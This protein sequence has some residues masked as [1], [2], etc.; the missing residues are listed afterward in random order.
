MS[1]VPGGPGSGEPYL[2]DRGPRPHGQVPQHVMVPLLTR[3]T[4]ESMDAGYRVAAERRRAQGGDRPDGTPP[5]RK[6]SWVTAVA[7]AIFGVLVTVAAVQT[8]RNAD[9][10]ALGRAS[11]AERVSQEQE[12][13]R[14]LQDRAGELRGQNAVAEAALRDLRRREE[15]LTNRVSRV[16]TRTGYLAVRGPGLRVTVED[17]PAD[18]TLTA[19]QDEDLHLLVDGLWAAGAEA[20]AINGQRLTVLSP[21]QNT[22]G[23]I[24]VNVRPLNPPYVVEAIGD[25]DRMEGRLLASINGSLFYSVARSLGFGFDV[26]DDVNLELPAARVRTLRSAEGG[27]SEDRTEESEEDTTP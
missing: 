4:Q 27:S 24:H 14:Q 11:L 2:R 19:V 5:A 13:V 12:L 1:A 22:G 7:V 3:L 6:V 10:E 15:Q 25:P 17:G 9:V 26:Q 21:I 8:S 23:A 20:I 18:G 16:G